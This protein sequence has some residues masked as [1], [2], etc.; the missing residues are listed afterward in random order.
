MSSK[1]HMT[2][3][4]IK[5]ESTDDKHKDEVEVFS[6]SW[7][8]STPQPAGGGGGGSGVGKPSFTDLNFTHRFD[9]ASPLLWRACAVGEHFRE[10]TL[11][12]SKQGK[13]ALDFLILKMSDVVVTSV[14][15]SDS[16]GSDSSME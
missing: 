4:N 8:V 5:G 12:E 13:E 14:S 3:G 9:K 6:W 11:S 10:A 16:S 1:I 15:A 7:G 2:I